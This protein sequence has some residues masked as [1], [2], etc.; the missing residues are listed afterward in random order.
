M[1]LVL[2]LALGLGLSGAARSEE[3]VECIMSTGN[4]L[5]KGWVA[6]NMF[7]LLDFDGKP[8]QVYDGVIK[9]F[10]KSE[11]PIEAKVSEDTDA[12]LTFTWS[13][14][15]LDDK[16]QRFKMNYR[17]SFFR[18]SKEI[19]VSAKPMGYRD[20]LMARGKCKPAQG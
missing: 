15:A 14:F 7:V 20:H 19:A 9:Y 10:K 11:D 13:L 18:N 16:G 5:Q 1:K 2:A 4:L 17:A 3:I 12:S 8:V 6:P